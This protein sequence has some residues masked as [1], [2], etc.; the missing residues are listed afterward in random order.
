MTGGSPWT[1]REGL[2]GQDGRVS[3]EPSS[4]TPAS[5][6]SAR[7]LLPHSAFLDAS[8]LPL[9]VTSLHFDD[10]KRRYGPSVVV[11]NLVKSR[12]KR[13]RETVLRRELSVAINMMNAQVGGNGGAWGGGSNG[14]ARFGEFHYLNSLKGLP[15]P[16]LCR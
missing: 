5:D 9:Q 3:R 8:P 14:L 6:S 2:P 1:G 11:L 10:L 4:L 16:L 12:E 15:S 7:S 13:P